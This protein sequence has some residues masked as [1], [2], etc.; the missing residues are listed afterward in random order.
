MSRDPY[1]DDVRHANAAKTHG[2]AD[3]NPKKTAALAGRT[4]RT[5]RRWRTEGKG[6]PVD[7]LSHYVDNHPNPWPIIHRLQAAGMRWVRSLSREE[8]IREIRATEATDAIE[9]GE[10]TANRSRRGLCWLDRAAAAR[11]DGS[12]DAKLDA[13]Y[14]RAAEIRLEERAVYGE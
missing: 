2:M 9:E 11:K 10:D 7:Q 6:S 13:L 12:T 3:P 8:L 14:T 5:A 1:R 4:D